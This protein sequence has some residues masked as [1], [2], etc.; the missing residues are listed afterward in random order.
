M[1]ILPGFLLLLAA[2]H[3]AA[4]PYADLVA[5]AQ[6]AFGQQ[7]Y[8][9]ATA[10]LDVA[11][12][13]RPYSLFLT[14]NRIATR[15]LA[16]DTD[17]AMHLARSVAARGLFVDL[18]GDA[19]DALRERADFPGLEASLAANKVPRGDAELDLESP[20]SALLPEALAR[21]GEDWLVGSVRTGGILRAARLSVP[22]AQLSG[23]V[24]DIE[25]RGT[26]LLAAVNRRPPYGQMVRGEPSS[27]I[28]ELELPS[29]RTRRSV[30]LGGDAL[31]G[32]LEVARDGRIF[33]TD[34]IT[35]RLV[36]VEPGA[37]VIRVLSQDAR[38]ANLQGLALDE[39]RN[40]LY[41]AD[42]LAG[43]FVVD[44]DTGETEAMAGPPDAHLGGID[45]LY[46]YRG[47][48]IGI[49]NGTMPQ[50]IVR[51]RLDETG[52]A[53]ARVDVLQQALA[54]WNEPTHGVVV[55]DRLYYLAT[56]NWPAY[57][58]DGSL[59]EGA[60][61]SPLRIMSVTLD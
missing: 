15:A 32:D 47:D 20:E 37:D 36:F 54:G 59:R 4:E 27:A 45:G 17:G 12:Q 13:Q 9:A 2:S 57:D 34:S 46:L 14:R 30:E 24:Y 10:A 58:D 8:L 50:R 21:L 16:G 26:L 33:A 19:F 38:F 48:L 11:Q 56:S 35:P 53:V 55:D 49:Q 28:I 18:S 23:G 25:V 6:A 7:D 1:R 40:R 5:R 39:A 51:V 22:V 44:A 43:L 29:G 31:I 52:T 61:L 3:A 60:S 42:Y 41:V